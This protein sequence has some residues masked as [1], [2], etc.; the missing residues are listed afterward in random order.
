MKERIIKMFMEDM[1]GDGRSK[2][3]YVED[4]DFVLEG[5]KELNDKSII[6]MVIEEDVCDDEEY[7]LFCWDRWKVIK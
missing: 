3:E 6:D 5:R 4:M 1:E 7:V 2:K